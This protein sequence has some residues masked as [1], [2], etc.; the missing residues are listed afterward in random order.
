MTIRAF[1]KPILP[2]PRNDWE[3]DVLRVMQEII[4]NFDDTTV[5]NVGD[6]I[7]TG[8]TTARTGFLL[9]DGAA[10]SRAKYADLFAAIGTTYGVG[11]G[12][13]TFNL[14]DLTAVAVCDF[15]IKF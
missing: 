10:V 7:G 6:I 9:C 8:P 2:H 4:D 3:T 11:D 14:P 1:R 5:L 15:M 12:S 13:T